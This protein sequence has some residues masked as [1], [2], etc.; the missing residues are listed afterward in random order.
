M[1]LGF[2]TNPSTGTTYT[3]GTQT[4]VWTGIAWAIQTQAAQ[5]PQSITVGTGTLT[6]SI[7]GG[8][9][10]INGSTVLTT[11]TIAKSAVSRLYAGTDTRVSANVGEITVWNNSTLQSVTDRGSSTTNSIHITNSVNSI[12]TSS[13]AVIID[14]GVGIG[15]DLYIGGDFYV[16][17]HTV[18]T[19][20]SFANQVISGPDILIT[21][22]DTGV[23]Y[24]SDISTLQTVTSRGFTTTNQVY[25]A[26]TTNST[27]SSTGAVVIEGGLGVGGRI[28]SESV[29]IADAIFD[30]MSV[31]INNTAT[32]V[33]DYYP[34]TQFRSAK[35]VIQIDSGVGPTAKFEV[36][37]ILLLVD[38]SGTIYA[39]E[40]AV[41]SS[42]GELGEFSAALDIMSNNVNLYFTAYQASDKILK[43]L[44]T[45][46][47]A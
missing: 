37:E 27:S 39:T 25:F 29:Q 46:L 16:K 23:I 13:G 47:A 43:I 31:S 19:T 18:I 34:F 32:V 4:Y 11:A 20:A 36:I 17:G 9:I 8:N 10:T 22:T 35:Y 1:A 45:G 30:S 24:F 41:L 6:I 40:Y 5:N 21:A 7:S 33:V 12:D 15:K 14:G 44:R 2:P 26:N 28:Y 42:A 38:N 3:L